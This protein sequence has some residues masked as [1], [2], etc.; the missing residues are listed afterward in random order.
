MNI[1]NKIKQIQLSLNELNYKFYK[2]TLLSQSFYC[3]LESKGM[4]PENSML[5]DLYP[6]GSNTYIVDIITKDMKIIK[7]DIDLDF[8]NLTIYE[9]RTKEYMKKS[10][11]KNSKEYIALG[12][13]K[14]TKG[15]K[16]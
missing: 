9:D 14:K 8:P 12:L 4:I 3:Q 7:I 11:K 2:K 1:C 13:Y 15:V 10:K 16:C 5:T 6:D